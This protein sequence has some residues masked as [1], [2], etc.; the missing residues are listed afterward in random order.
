MKWANK[1]QNNFNIYNVAFKKKIKKNTCRYHYQ[2][3]NDM[4]HSSQDIE[5]NILLVILN[6]FLP[7]Y[8]PKKPQKSKFWKMKNLLEILSFYICVP[9]FELSLCTS[10]IVK[11]ILIIAI[12]QFQMLQKCKAVFFPWMKKKDVKIT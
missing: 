12:E 3:L 7:F 5:Q 11:W 1:K 4:I 6:Q 2:N 10:Q 8:L 9:G